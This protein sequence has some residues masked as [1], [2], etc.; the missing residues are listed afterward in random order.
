ML[1]FAPELAECRFDAAARELI[2]AEFG[3]VVFRRAVIAE[4]EVADSIGLVEPVVDDCCEFLDRE[5]VV[6]ALNR[7]NFDLVAL[8]AVIVVEL[9]PEID[10]LVLI[11]CASELA[12]KFCARFVEFLLRRCSDILG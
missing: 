10:C 2:V 1:E 6:V 11:A 8:G 12:L 4:N 7:L 9:S 3:V 5:R